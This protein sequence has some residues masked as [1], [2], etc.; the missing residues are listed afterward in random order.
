MSDDVRPSLRDELQRLPESATVRAQR[1]ETFEP[2][3][4]CGG[5]V[6]VRYTETWRDGVLALCQGCSQADSGR[7][8]LY[9]RRRAT[10]DHDDE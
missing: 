3:E 7:R 8:L 10:N 6:R 1:S 2:C 5:H 4:R 9:Y